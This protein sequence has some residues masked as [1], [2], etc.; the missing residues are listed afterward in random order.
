MNGDRRTPPQGRDL[1]R[2]LDAWLATSGDRA[3]EEVVSRALERTQAMSQQPGWLARL[4]TGDGSVRGRMPIGVLVVALLTLATVA[5][6]V[7][8]TLLDRE[9]RSPSP[10]PLTA[11]TPSPRPTVTAPGVALPIEGR[12]ARSVE[13]GVERP[14]GLGWA[15]GSLWLTD[16]DTL[17]LLRID[18]GAGEIVSRI[19]MAAHGC[20]PF[21]ADTRSLWLASCG[22]ASGRPN[23]TLRVDPATNRL[24]AALR[25]DTE[26]GVGAGTL[27]GGTWIIA[28]VERGVLRRYDVAS[29]EPTGEVDLG[30][31]VRHLAAGFGSL[32]VSPRTPGVTEVLRID[33]A[34]GTVQARVA[35]S[36]EPGFLLTGPTGIW[37]AQPG[38][39][40]VARIDPVTDRAVFEA[41]A[42]EGA[43]QLA[44]AADGSIWILGSETLLRI[45]ASSGAQLDRL[46]VPRHRTV[47]G[48]GEDQIMTMLVTVTDDATWYALAGRLVELAAP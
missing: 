15:Y 40:L 33:P 19:P 31:P 16:D 11:V 13:T 21:V 32:W 34:S 18:P 48:S 29:G 1:D 24:A 7:G 28:D 38:Q 35:L 45:D 42:N 46:S 20:G 9:E 44:L 47:G 26:H 22:G 6:G 41:L 4:K 17:E 37:V 39:R 27:G 12:V 10:T 3:P 8:G 36:G 25:D 14:A 5:L 23:G 2:R 43:D 30:I